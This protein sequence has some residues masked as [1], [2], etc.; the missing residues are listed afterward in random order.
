MKNRHLG[1]ALACALAAFAAQAGGP[2]HPAFDR[3]ASATERK[4]EANPVI[5]GH[6]ASPRWQLVHANAEHPAM[7]VA[8]RTTQVDP[9]TYLVQPP[10]SVH[11]ALGPEP[12]VRVSAYSR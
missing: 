7:V 3:V 10:A 5:V 4:A 9:N 8:R 1:I 2:Q 6:P 12:D 11:W